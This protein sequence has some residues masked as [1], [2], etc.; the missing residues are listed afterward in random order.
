MQKLFLNSLMN[1]WITFDIQKYFCVAREQLLNMLNIS[2]P[3]KP[4]ICLKLFNFQND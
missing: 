3:T 4:E 2:T 1:H